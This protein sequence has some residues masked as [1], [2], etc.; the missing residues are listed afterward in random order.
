[1]RKMG[2]G[3]VLA[4]AL[5]LT[6][7]AWASVVYVDVPALTAEADR[8]VIGDV[9]DVS[10]FWDDDAGLIRSR[11]TVEVSDVLFDRGA[12]Y[13]DSGDGRFEVLEMSGGTVG[14]MTLRVS[15]L[16]VF[17]VG[18]HV[19][20]FLGDSEI[21]LVQA[22]QGAYLTD[23]ELVA[24]MAPSCR[25]VF[26]DTLR[27]LADMLRDI[28]QALPPGTTLRRVTPYDGSFQIP[29]SQGRYALCGYDWTYKASPMGENYVINPNCADSAAGS[30]SE[31]I[32]AIQNGPQQW[33]NAGANFEFTYGGTSSSTSVTY[34]GVNLVYF[35]TTPPDGGS[36]IAATYI[37]TSGGTDITENDLVFNDRD[38]VFWNGS[39]SCSGMMDIWNIAA[40]E[41][42]HYLCL[43]H[44]SNSSA[45]MYYAA[46]YCETYKRTLHQDDI[47]GIV[48][49]YG[50]GPSDPYPPTPDPMTWSSTP[51]P[52]GLSSVSMV[53]TTATDADSPPVQYYFDFTTGS[54]G[55]NDSGWQ[56]STSYTDAGLEANGEYTYRVKAR[57]SAT[58]T[59]NETAYSAT[60]TTAT[61]IETPNGVTFGTVSDSYITL[62][63]DG[64]LSNLAAGSSGAYF[65]STTAGGD[66]GINLWIKTT[67]DAAYSLDPDT[68]Y[69]FR[70]KARNRLGVE[71]AYTSSSS[72]ATLASTPGAPT[73]SNVTNNSMDINVDPNGNPSYTV[74]AI[75]CTATSPT[76][77]TWDGQYVNASGNPSASAVW[78]TDGDWGTT[79]VQGLQSATQYT[80]AVK[81]RNQ[82]SVETAFGTGASDTTTSSF[83]IGDLNCDGYVNNFDIDPF[84]LVITSTPP[85]TDYYS[86]YPGCDHM[87]ADIN[88]DGTVNNFDID[89]FVDLIT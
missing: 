79:T 78:R 57:D 83:A 5:C 81:A 86:A 9:I 65:D 60:E 45:T 53:C 88:Q 1:M 29:F 18:D 38:Y 85:Y 80:F 63:V 7:T 36:Y 56:S 74:F 72:K 11:T 40:H 30:T 52:D 59:A 76:D 54:S 14:D 4:V 37:W 43:D 25:R 34:N 68:S 47:D 23:G 49:I 17:E 75:M 66:T 20:L 39:G 42:G 58:P 69:T 16:P 3:L 82:E 15:V 67:T 44:S 28:E 48:A 24:R 33:N 64:T 50:A 12:G 8:V 89:P 22:F 41:F 13:V 55:G 87:L 84:V 62:N 32:A 61:L 51:S 2:F 21:G 70:V 31:Q 27:P 73:L 19:L 77:G 35:D 6:A 26:E 46:G 10:S 71:T